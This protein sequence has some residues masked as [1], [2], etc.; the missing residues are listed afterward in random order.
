MFVELLQ[1]SSADFSFYVFSALVNVITSVGLGLFILFKQ[2]RR[3]LNQAFA[4]FATAVA[5]WSGGYFL[6][7]LASTEAGALMWVRFMVVGA[8]FSAFTYLHFIVELLGATR[9]YLHVLL[10]GYGLA[11]VF[12]ALSGSPL[13]IAGLTQQFGFQY[14]PQAGPLFGVFLLLWSTVLV[15]CGYLLVGAYRTFTERTRRIQALFALVAMLL[16]FVSVAANF[17]T[18]YGVPI[19]PYANLLLSVHVIAISYAALRHHL[20]QVSVIAV[21]L[22][23]GALWFLLLLLL[24]TSRSVAEFALHTGIFAGTIVSGVFLIKSVTRER[25]QRAQLE[26]INSDLRE[27]DE[28]KSEF[29]SLAAHQLRTPLTSIKGYAS[30]LLDGTFGQIPDR[31][32]T[33]LEHIERSTDRMVKMVNDY[34]TISRIE[35]DRLEYSWSVRT[36]STILAEVDGDMRQTVEGN[37]L[38]FTVEQAEPNVSVRVD[39]EKI[40]QA[41][42]NIVDNA[43]TYTQH[44]SV[45]LRATYSATK[46]HVQIAVIDT[47]IG[48]TKDEQ[49]AV[50]GKFSRSERG[51]TADASGSGLGLYIAKRI[52]EAHNGSI[53]VHSQGKQC[54]TTVLIELPT[55]R[56]AS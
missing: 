12:A 21:E 9:R 15:Y 53:A 17:L 18:W 49:E 51:K 56:S 29:I 10:S 30:M 47:G 50:F 34:L 35:Q 44:G 55:H 38:T 52:V 11:C 32:A 46:R 16:A 2:P 45:R 31:M 5:I 48:L 37:G 14:W 25:R 6:W 54:G 43:V 22:L 26:R 24:F 41:I 28:R 13:M 36:V 40:I 27:L 4:L 23:V 3:H 33:P 39:T 1:V 8:V 42:D 20:F 7:Q 19:P